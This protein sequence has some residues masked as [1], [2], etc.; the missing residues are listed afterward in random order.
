MRPEPGITAVNPTPKCTSA[1][2]WLSV[3][4]A[5]AKFQVVPRRWD[6]V[7]AR[8]FFPHRGHAC[9]AVRTTRC[10]SSRLAPPAAC[11]AIPWE[12]VTT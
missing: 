6:E 11:T 8:G 4:T 12:M 7:V 3:R 9:I 1:A 10:N 2:V 5:E